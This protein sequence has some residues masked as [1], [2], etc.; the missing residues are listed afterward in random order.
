MVHLGLFF[1]GLDDS[2]AA[3]RLFRDFVPT[4][5]DDTG[6]LIAAA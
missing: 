6:A 1:W 5:P 4:L 3:L 2:V